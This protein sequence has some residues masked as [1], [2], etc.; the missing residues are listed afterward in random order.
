[1]NGVNKVIL[2][3]NVG[4]DPEIQHLEGGVTVARFPMATTESYKDK[5]GNKVD[6]TEWHNIVVWRGLADVTEKIVH[7][8]TQLYIEGR[9]R[10]RQWE[11]KEKN[12]RYTTEIV[13][14]VINVTGRRADSNNS[15]NNDTST[16]ASFD[17]NANDGNDLPF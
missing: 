6:Q 11:D 2:L 13:A 5:N 17:L 3:G 10:T 9:L 15:N 12:K 8:G 7:K 4:K 16:P 1:M 14:D